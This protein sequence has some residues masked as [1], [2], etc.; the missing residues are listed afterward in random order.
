MT[1]EDAEK[2]TARLSRDCGCI[3]DSAPITD[4]LMAAYNKGWDDAE[5]LSVVVATN[6]RKSEYREPPERRAFR[7]R[8][9]AKV[10]SGKSVWAK[11]IKEK[12]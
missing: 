5:Q 8:L 1:R 10:L 7:D 11:Y 3:N 6:S 9:I 12:K 4:A 2:I